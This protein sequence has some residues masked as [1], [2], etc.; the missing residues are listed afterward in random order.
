[1]SAAWIGG[2]NS[3]RYPIITFV[4]F[5]TPAT[6]DI[7]TTQTENSEIQYFYSHG[8]RSQRSVQRSPRHDVFCLGMEF[9]PIAY[10][11][12]RAPN[13]SDPTSLLY[14]SLSYFE[15]G[16]INQLIHPLLDISPLFFM[17]LRFPFGTEDRTAATQVHHSYSTSGGNLKVVSSADAGRHISPSL[18]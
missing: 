15:N 3:T 9:V 2:Y 4:L 17:D 1:M 6:P 13:H 10:P 7:K 14:P 11:T 16:I 8:N 5:A 12:L 18:G